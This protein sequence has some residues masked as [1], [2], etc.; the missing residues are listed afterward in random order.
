[1]VGSMTWLASG[2]EAAPPTHSHAGTEASTSDASKRDALR[3]I[4]LDKLSDED[5]V[6]VKS[7]LS[8]VSL[9]RRLPIKTIDCDPALYIFLV[10]HPDVVVNIWEIFKISKLRLRQ[11]DENRY[12]VL[13]SNGAAMTGKFVYQSRNTHVL[14][15]E[16][17]YQGSLFLKPVKGRGVLVL[18]NAYTQESNG[19][20]TITSR[21][22]CFLS[23]DSFGAEIATKTVSPL[24]GKT[25]DNNFTQTL[26][27]VGSL[28]RT[29]ELNSHGVQRL[30]G[31]L[32]HVQP[33]VRTQ[34]AELA[35][36]IP[37]RQA[38][39]AEAAKRREQVEV[40]SQANPQR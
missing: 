12:Q 15:G 27:F 33:E 30:A 2:G 14:Y 31:Q 19:R 10:R 26:A 13:E 5:R 38:A 7:V 32:S 20:Y 6:K 17:T 36:D 40:A 24:L 39:A 9:F 25:V 29:A 4:P 11:S 1:L 8:E 21:L 28:S 3:S 35:A 23:I 34:F 18:K 16:G 22:D 37:D